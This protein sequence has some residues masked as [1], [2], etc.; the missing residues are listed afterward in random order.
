MNLRATRR[1][2]LLWLL[3]A[4]PVASAA[5]MPW[6]FPQGG[7]WTVLPVLLWAQGFSPALSH[8]CKRE[9]AMFVFS[10]CA[11]FVPLYFV[12]VYILRTVFTPLA[13]S[14]QIA[15]TFFILGL[16]VVCS[17]YVFHIVRPMQGGADEEKLLED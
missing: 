9:R 4:I 13:F 17:A 16:I 15:V 3:M 2:G 8:F 5:L 1:K 14:W 10:I 7:V 11:I 6:L 12:V